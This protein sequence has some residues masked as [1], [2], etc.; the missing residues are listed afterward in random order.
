[1]IVDAL[2][3]D[4]LKRLCETPGIAGREDQMIRVVREEMGGLV[5]EI[6]TDALGNVIGL[7]RAA[8]APVAGTETRRVMV[9]AHMDEIGFLV[10]HIDEKGYLRLHPVGGFD[11]SNLVSQRVLVHS[12]NG[13]TLRGVV[14]LAAKP[15]HLLG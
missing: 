1:M 2:N 7:K 3:F 6:R 12:S 13:T 8:V 11:A 9:A 10:R 4:L 15:I 5:D 14:Q